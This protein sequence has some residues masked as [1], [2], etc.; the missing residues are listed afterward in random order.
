[1]SERILEALAKETNQAILSLLAIEPTYT[2]SI[3]ELLGYSESDV[4]RRLSRLEDAGLVASEWQHVDGR[5]VK[6]YRLVADEVSIRI[7]GEG[8]AI[9]ATR[10]GTDATERTL[11]DRLEVRI[12]EP[13]TFVGRGDELAVLEGPAPVVLVEGIPGIGKTSLAARFALDHR[14]E[15]PVFF[16]SFTGT[17]SLTWLA[18]RVG[19][20]QAR[21]DDPDLLEAVEAE[22]PLA[23][24]RR[25]LLEALEDPSTITVLDE[26]GRIRDQDL[27][28]LIAD[29][30][31]HVREGK[32]VVTGRNLPAFDPSADHVERLRLD[33]LSTED[34]QRLLAERSI[35]ADEALAAEVRRRLGGHP[36][37]I[38]LLAEAAGDAATSLEGLLE[39]APERA[40]EDYLLDEVHDRLTDSERRVLSYASVLHGRFTREDLAAIY[41][42]NPEGALVRLRRRRL[43]EVQG[44]TYRVHD[45]L[46]SFFQERL[47]DPAAIH[48]EAAEHAL[49][50]GTLEARLE[51]LHHLLEA[52]KRARVVDLLERDLDLEEFDLVEDGYHNLYL[53]VLQQ[54][55]PD[56]IAA[57][58][59]AGLVHDEIGDV[60]LHR[61]EHE[62]ALDHY[63]EAAASFREAGDEQRLADLAWKRAL[64]LIELDRA[65]EARKRV[66]AGLTEHGPDERTR[67]RLETLADELDVEV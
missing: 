39:G 57:A 51:A 34:V 12:P 67:G 36:L 32:L 44:D 33:G 25:L 10:E 2:R 48:E 29:A 3:S 53:D 63:R 66:Q 58:G 47:D 1:M 43:L 49:G 40:I 14:D 41:P 50:Q 26:T 21:H 23:D 24:R 52:G 62:Q 59:R 42:G 64:A 27:E 37:A 65:G 15:R 60:R 4:S 35:P 13:E 30:I 38:N 54:L 18:H 6:V 20:F 46:A 31:E 17:E 61:G 7:D 8:L 19:V 9:E 55:D 5:N 16:H 28:E 22:V 45:L 11:L 56:T